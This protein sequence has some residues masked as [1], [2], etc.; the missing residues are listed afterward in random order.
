MRGHGIE[1]GAL[2][3]LAAT[4]WAGMASAQAPDIPTVV[5]PLRV[6]TDHNNVNI[7]SGQTSIDG[8]SLGVPGAPNLR[9][10][11]VQNAA[12]YVRGNISGQAGQTVTGS[13][14]VHTGGAD[15]ESFRCLDYDCESVTGS[16]STFRPSGAGGRGPAV[17]RQAG[18]GASYALSVRLVN[19][20]GPPSLMQYYA[21]SV[22][23]PNGETIT[24]SYNTASLPGQP[25]VTYRR[26]I[27][28]QSNLGYHITISYHDGALGTMEWNS[29]LQATLYADAA[30]TV[31]LQQLSY[32]ADGTTITD[33][34]GRSWTC[35]A[36]RNSMGA[37]VEVA[38]GSLQLPDEGAPALQV[39][40]APPPPGLPGVG[41]VG[42][43]TRDGVPWNYAYAGVGHA[44]GGS[45]I[46]NQ[47]TVTGPDGFNQVYAITQSDQRNVI[48]RMTDSL[49]RV[50]DFTFDAAYRPIRIV[51]PEQNEVSVTYDPQGNIIERR[52]K[53]RPG[54]GSAPD[55]VQTAA[56]P[57]PPEGIPNMCQVECWRPIWSRDARNQQTDYLYNAS[58][59]LTQQDDPAD[60]QGVRRRTIVAYTPSPNGQINRRSAVR[61]CGVGPGAA[62]TCGT[63]QEHRTEYEY[64]GNTPLVAV[65][66][67][68]DLAAGTMLETRHSYDPAGRLIMTD[69][70]LPGE[71]DTLHYRY[72]VHGRR[73]WEIGAR[74]PNGLRIATRTHYRNSDDKPVLVETGTLPAHDSAVL[75]VF[76]ST[77]IA[78]DTRRNPERE[79]LSAAPTGSGQ[80]PLTISTLV[81]RTFDQSNRPI[82]EAVRMNPAVFASLPASACTLSTQGAHGP[83][84]I[85]KNVYDEA[86]QR[87][88]LRVGVGSADEGAAATWAYNLNGQITRMIDG[89]GNRAELRYDRH[90]RQDR[91]TFPS[92]TR[93]S[94]YN[95]ADP[96]SALATAGAVNPADYEEYSYDANGNRL[97]HRK[98]D[99]S[100]LTFTYD[101]LN[102]VI[103]KVVPERA[104]LDPIHTRDVHYGYDLRNLQL[105][106]R[107]DSP[108][109]DGVT[110]AWDGFGRPLSSSINL[111]GTTRTLGYQHREDGARTRLT[112]PD[113]AFFSMDRDAL[114]R[115]SWLNDPLGGGIAVFQYDVMGLPLGIGRPGA[116]TG[117]W[118]TGAGRLF[119]QS[120]YLAPGLES[121]WVFGHNP[122]G[123]IAAVTR[124]NDDYAWQGHY[125]VNRPYTANGLNQ[126]SAAGGAAFGYDANGNLTSDGSRTYTYDIENRLVGA[127]GG[128]VL[129]YDP[130][131]RLWR[132]AGGASGTTTYLYDSDALVAEYNASGTLA[133]RYVHGDGAD[134]PLV[135]YD[136][137]GTAASAR[138]NLLAD[139]QGSIIATSDNAANRLSINR[140]D[141][142]G[143]PAST[144]SG[145]FQY[146]GQ[147]WLPDLG[148]YHYKARVY[149]PTI[150]RFL[151]TDPIGYDDQFNLYAYVGND[152]INLT[153]P[154]GTS[155]ECTGTRL[156]CGG[157][158]GGLC[159]S[160]SGSGGLGY[161]TIPR[162]PRQYSGAGSGGGMSRYS[163][164]PEGPEGGTPPVYEP[165]VRPVRNPALCPMADCDGNVV[166]QATRRGS[167]RASAHTSGGRG[168]GRAREERI[169]RNRERVARNQ[170][171]AS[172]RLNRLAT[173]VATGTIISGGASLAGWYFYGEQFAR[174]TFVITMAA[175]ATWA[176]LRP[177][178]DPR[179]R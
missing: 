94:A 22:T 162:G 44:V 155:S 70:P 108:S 40:P 134:V 99:G 92:T 39:A 81:Q 18:S 159:M 13:Y 66:R 19:Q 131:G 160:C 35:A 48:D 87:R 142:Y 178:D 41:L 166:V 163:L 103:S 80:D 25:S 47:V 50:T 8:P 114:G 124:T 2:A 132:T 148:M 36:C 123:Q 135:R 71:D 101:N 85:T 30:P 118:F 31:A 43:V 100:V 54:A 167:R 104:G 20:A 84:R 73:T 38:S 110:N 45:L 56:Y 9:F 97:T 98:R 33:L 17:Y 129:T 5:S 179:C 6:E 96:V 93:P 119:T 46:Y 53:A 88:Q 7:I 169:R 83:D 24:Y 164:E 170:Y 65:E 157:S 152:P 78:Y 177:L 1:F 79:T 139:H 37:T 105:F 116:N 60:A 120:H 153:D 58:G 77:A 16:G 125:A 146:T 174:R 176:F 57:E 109:G 68:R 28:L 147:I 115:T 121:L 154:S 156:A 122:A 113:G 149:S 15:S 117:Y 112:H 145:R 52:A 61:V 82:C 26:P 11:R 23:W 95:D 141:E 12:P 126:Y 107:F 136:G 42:S 89:N 49:G 128:L 76:R 165:P 34:N 172:L 144:N 10:D 137:A 86:G 32:S 75:T 69:G 171:C 102:R 158:N 3:L 111:G 51:Y 133:H 138:I 175:T 14:S 63:N 168:F 59:Q 150:G 4:G 29:P 27:R 91:W 143:I 130:L 140:Y 151:Q 90:M 173:E 72:D 161:P 62:T 106:A 127:S 55:L 64:W 21:A 67:Q 74:A